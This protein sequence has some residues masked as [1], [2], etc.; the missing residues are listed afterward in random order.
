MIC[1]FSHMYISVIKINEKRVYGYNVTERKED[2]MKWF[3]GK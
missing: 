3:G 2:Y 1:M